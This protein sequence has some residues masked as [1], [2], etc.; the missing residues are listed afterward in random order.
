MNDKSIYEFIAKSIRARRIEIGMTQ[1]ELG[2]SI[3][4]DGQ[5]IS[6]LERFSVKPSM[7][8][9]YAISK[10]LNC[11]SYSLLPPGNIPDDI[12]QEIR[13]I[14]KLQNCNKGQ[15]DFI[16]KYVDLYL[17]SHK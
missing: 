17:E 5:Y 3:G 9:V 10:S 11:L 6:K 8:R 2:A 15:K 14:T 1:E 16:E 4:S 12:S 13:I 7:E